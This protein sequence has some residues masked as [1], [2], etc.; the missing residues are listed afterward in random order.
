MKTGQSTLSDGPSSP[1]PRAASQAG[2]MRA[3]GCL[4]VPVGT[5]V[6]PWRVHVR[7]MR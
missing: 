5:C 6:C 7:R 4:C 2:A 3:S 1:K